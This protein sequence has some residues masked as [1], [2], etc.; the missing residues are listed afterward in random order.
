M[1][2]DLGGKSGEREGEEN[3]VGEGIVDGFFV[4]FVEIRREL[5]KEV[6][7]GIFLV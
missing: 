3:C 4:F 6:F 1:V 2:G 5:E 7:D